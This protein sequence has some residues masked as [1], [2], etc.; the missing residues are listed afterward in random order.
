MSAVTYAA[1]SFPVARTSVPS[2]AAAPAPERGFFGRLLDAVIAA[3]AA[4][5]EREVA[6]YRALYDMDRLR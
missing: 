4:Q 3:R 2:V 1:K 6:R 5:A